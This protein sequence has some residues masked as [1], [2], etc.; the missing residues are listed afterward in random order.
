LRFFLS[1]EG[2][3]V[4]KV[5]ERAMTFSTEVSVVGRSYLKRARMSAKERRGD[6]AL[7]VGRSYLKRARMSTKERRWQPPLVSRSRH[8]RVFPLPR[9]TTWASSI[10]FLISLKLKPLVDRCLLAISNLSTFSV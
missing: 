10:F 1:E 7:R 8:L 6:G 3:D 5:E 2:E 9:G 4:D